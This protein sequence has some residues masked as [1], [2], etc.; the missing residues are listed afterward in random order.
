[1]YYLYLVENFGNLWYNH[2]RREVIKVNVLHKDMGDLLSN[3]QEPPRIGK[4]AEGALAK[5]QY[6]ILVKQILEYENN[7]DQDHEVML[8]L[9]SFGQMVS[10]RVENIGYVDP[11]IIIFYGLIDNKPSKLIQH[12]NQLSFLITS[13]E[14][15]TEAHKPRRIGFF[16]PNED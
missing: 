4:I 14:K 1:M 5:H 16:D 3:V 12:I 11:S 2:L 8:L 15:P 6:E 7:L 10:M 13:V 9:S